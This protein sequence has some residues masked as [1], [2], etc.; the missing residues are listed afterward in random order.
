MPGIITPLLNPARVLLNVQ[1][2]KRTAALHEVAKLLDGDAN[3]A[4]FQGFYDELLA[5]E[6]LDT[7]CLGNG[8]ALPHARTEHVKSIVMAVGRSPGGVL[9]ENSN[10]TVRLIFM[11]GT[12]KSNPGAYLQVVGALCKILK[13]AGNRDALLN[14]ATPADFAAA[15]TAAEAKLRLPA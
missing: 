15:L 5:R 2:T 6:R 10:E 1:S 9:F 12:P 4:N 3:V 11:L 14:A 8:I 13:D 7:T